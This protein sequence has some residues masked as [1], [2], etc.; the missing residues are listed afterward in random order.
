ME[1]WARALAWAILSVADYGAFKAVTAETWRVILAARGWTLSRSTP[2]PDGDV[3]HYHHAKEPGIA[4][5]V[6][7]T[8]AVA[9]DP[10]YA[11]SELAVKLGRSQGTPHAIVVAEAL[12]LQRF[13][14][15]GMKPEN[16]LRTA[17]DLRAMVAPAALAQALTGP[18]PPEEQGEAVV[19][20]ATPVER[21]PQPYQPVDAVP[22][23]AWKD[24]ERAWF[25]ALPG[26]VEVAVDV[27]RK[28]AKRAAGK[29]SA[30]EVLI[31]IRD[32]PER[33][34][35]AGENGERLAFPYQYSAELA[36]RMIEA[37]PSLREHMVRTKS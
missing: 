11:Y 30:R 1:A 2:T 37:D 15:S 28:H 26:I 9:R 32:D 25:K 19:T 22:E 14:Q 34:Q 24:A 21:P 3:E 6:L 7:G 13:L 23:P 4:L 10:G 17:A 27:A 20:Q 18:V 8:A 36:R 35:R 29:V 12:C 31:A 16:A 5:R 33:R